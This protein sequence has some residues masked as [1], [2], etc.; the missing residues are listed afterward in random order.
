MSSVHD[1]GRD[2]WTKPGVDVTTGDRNNE[3]PLDGSDGANEAA[4]TLKS[5]NTNVGGPSTAATVAFWDTAR[6]RFSSWYR[7]LPHAGSDSGRKNDTAWTFPEDSGRLDRLSMSPEASPF[8]LS[9]TG[10]TGKPDL[11]GVCE[12]LGDGV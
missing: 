6:D 12:A 1:E 3:E 11:L 5:C 10:C 2:I 4:W 8:V 7:P 9:N